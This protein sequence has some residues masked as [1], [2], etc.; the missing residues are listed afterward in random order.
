MPGF[1]HRCCSVSHLL[2][3]QLHFKT[4]TAGHF[5]DF[6]CHFEDLLRHGPAPVP[7]PPTLSRLRATREFSVV[8]T[9]QMPVRHLLY[10]IFE[11]PWS[12]ACASFL[13]LR[14]YARDHVAERPGSRDS[15]WNLAA[16]NVAF[17]LIQLMGK[18][19]YVT[20][21]S[22]TKG[23]TYDHGYSLNKHNATHLLRFVKEVGFAHRESTRA[24]CALLKADIMQPDS[25]TSQSNLLLPRP[26]WLYAKCLRSMRPPRYGTRCKSSGTNS[27]TSMIR[28]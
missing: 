22:G 8:D 24:A 27:S 17:S 11:E 2:L 14:R 23:F 20:D 21:R 3:L 16:R 5:E 15:D 6:L 19:L 7:P 12:L 18:E 28:S 9:R 10:S 25:R 26:H 13:E 1:G 4:D